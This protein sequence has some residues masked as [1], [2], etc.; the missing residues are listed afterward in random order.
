MCIRDSDKAGR[1][2]LWADM[3]LFDFEGDVYRSALVP[4]N[5]DRLERQLASVSPYCDEI[6]VYQYMGMMLSLIHIWSLSPLRFRF[7]CCSR[8]PPCNR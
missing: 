1:A 7:L 6:L 3:E 2:A 8:K 5:I 4:A